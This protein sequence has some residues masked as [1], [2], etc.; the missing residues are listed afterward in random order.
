MDMI[1]RSQTAFWLTGGDQMGLHLQLS[2]VCKLKR[3]NDFSNHG[4]WHCVFKIPSNLEKLNF[5]EVFGKSVSKLSALMIF[6]IQNVKY[7]G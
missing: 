2:K 6:L 5:N 7:D 1:F 3:A 4:T